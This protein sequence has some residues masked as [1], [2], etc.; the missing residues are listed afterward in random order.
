MRNSGGFFWYNEIGYVEEEL[1][2]YLEMELIWFGDKLGGAGK[3]E[4]KKVF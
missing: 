3:G 1:E 4:V 2:V